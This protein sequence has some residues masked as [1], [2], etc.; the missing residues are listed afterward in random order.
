VFNDLAEK[1]HIAEWRRAF[2]TGQVKASGQEQI[3]KLIVNVVERQE[4]RT[5]TRKAR[6]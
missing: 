5:R 6:R 2:Q 3:L 1:S 4:E